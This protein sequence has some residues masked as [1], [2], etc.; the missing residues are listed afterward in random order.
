MTKTKTKTK[1]KSYD[2]KIFETHNDEGVN[3][4]L[5]INIGD[6][7]FVISHGKT[8][9]R[10]VLY[11]KTDGDKSDLR[12]VAFRPVDVDEDYDLDDS[13]GDSGSSTINDVR[14]H[15][16]LKG[17]NALVTI[18]DTVFVV[19]YSKPTEKGEPEVKIGCWNSDDTGPAWEGVPMPM[20]EYMEAL[21]AQNESN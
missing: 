1:T 8:Q 6:K 16:G 9:F 18:G 11:Y 3:Q 20:E 5:T 2:L 15:Q 4:W 13:A 14:I 12:A 17:T 7:T 19:E 21:E 10:K